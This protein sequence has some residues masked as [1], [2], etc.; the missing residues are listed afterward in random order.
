MNRALKYY[1]IIWFKHDLPAGLSVFLVALP[2]C[3]GIAL[4]S[5][6]PL[7]SGIL[8]GIIGGLVV[9]LA[10][11][12]QLA[13]SGPAAGLSTMVAAAIITLGDFQLFMLAVMVAGFFQLALG[14]LKLGTIANYFPSS[15]IKGMLAAIGIIL[16]S[17][18]IPLALGY[19]KPDFWTSGFIQLFSADNFLGNIRSFNYHITRGAILIATISLVVLIVLQQPFAKKWKVIPAPLLV[20]VIGIVTNIIFTKIT[21]DYSLR[22]TQLVAI[23]SNIFD[24]IAFPDFSKLFSTAEIWKNGILIGLLASLETLLCIE[25]IDKLDK[26]NRITPVN[27]ELVAQ[28]I[29]NMACGLVGAI[30][31]TAVVV[32]G[33]ANVQAGARTKLSAFTHGLF[34]LLAVVLIPFVLNKIPYASL[35]A[36]LLI[37]GYNLTKPSLYINMWSLGRKQF[38]PFMI[39]IVVILLTDLL[40]GVSIGLL[41]SIYYIIHSNFKVEYKI[42]LTRHHGIE[43]QY[44]KL[45]N[46]VTFL[47]KV[48]L[49]KALDEVPEYC[50]LTIDGSESRQ[51]D[52]DILEIISEFKR[53]AHDRHIDLH[54]INISSVKVMSEK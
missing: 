10:S 29:G 42:S 3:L 36:V 8:S 41:I 18:Q 49:R 16:I 48:K 19:D 35:A 50:V 37:T 23:P 28:G 7:Y 15:V 44:I 54:L 33:A 46:N 27:R 21:S 31:M 2:L 13:V 32:R 34:L 17:K 14:L 40:I 24:S 25:A 53:K 4:A 20:V 22:P 51:I 26:R 38:I 47:N 5:G 12:S 52:Y 43:T 30:P 45:N 11:G 9:S 6:A 1:R 39:T